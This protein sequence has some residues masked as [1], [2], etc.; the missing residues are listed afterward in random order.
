MLSYRVKRR[1]LNHFLKRVSK[2]ESTKV[3]V[4]DRE[5]FVVKEKRLYNRSSTGDQLVVS[6]SQRPIVLHLGHSI[7][8]SGHLGQTYA[9]IAQNFYWPQIFWE[10]IQY[11]HTCPEC[12]LI[13]MPIIEVPFSCIAMDIVGPLEHSAPGHC[14]ILVVCDD[15]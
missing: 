15:A 2:D 10:G 14:N 8:M 3:S 5:M 12:P 11:C 9:H 7:P 6:K 4:L 13:N 1:L